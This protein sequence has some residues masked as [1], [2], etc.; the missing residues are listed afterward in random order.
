MG[1]RSIFVRRRAATRTS[2]SIFETLTDNGQRFAIAQRYMPEIAQ[3]GDK[4][5]L[6]VDGEPVPYALARMPQGDENRGNL[7]AGRQGRG[8]AAERARPLAR[9]ARSGPALAAA[10]C[11]SS[12]WT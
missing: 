11:C 1:G 9:R 3:S 2:T 7:A 12:A 4:R 8:P 5:M 10:A 6:L